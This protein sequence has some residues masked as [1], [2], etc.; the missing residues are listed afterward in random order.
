MKLGWGVR[1]WDDEFFTALDV[2]ARI[3]SGVGSWGVNRHYVLLKGTD[4]LLEPINTKKGRTPVILDVKYEPP[5]AVAKVLTPTETAWYNVMFLNAAART[6]EAQRR[7]TSFTDPYTGWVMLPDDNSI[8]QPYGVR[9][10]SPWKDSPGLDKLTDPHEVIEFMEQIAMATAT[11]HVRGTVGKK[12][13]D[14][15]HI[16]RAL[17]GKKK[18]R[19]KWRKAVTRLAGAYHE[20]VLLDYECFADCVRANYPAEDSSDGETED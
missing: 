12:P 1:Q 6:V 15:K 17:L 7:L 11:S 13:G 20:Q 9:Q 18:K 16:I 10:R 14:F 3:G 5:G 4:E 2:A 8:L 19:R